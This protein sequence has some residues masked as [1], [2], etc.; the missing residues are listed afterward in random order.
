MAPLDE[1]LGERV[2]HAFRTAVLSWRHR[3][4][5][6]GN[7]GDP[8]DQL[9]AQNAPIAESSLFRWGGELHLSNQ[10]TEARRRMFIRYRSVKAVGSVTRRH[11]TLQLRTT[12][13]A[14]CGIDP[15]FPESRASR[16]PKVLH[17]LEPGEG[18]QPT[19]Q[20]QPDR[21][22]PVPQRSNSGFESW[23]TAGRDSAPEHRWV[24]MC[25]HQVIERN[26]DHGDQ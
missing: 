19:K 26:A 4:E 21:E 10:R 1:L 9:T 3:D 7:L 13:E 11:P 5:E 20:K 16:S 15:R 8:H 22:N 23:P 6:W 14:S 2:H 17:L 12:Y 24:E 25:V 18:R